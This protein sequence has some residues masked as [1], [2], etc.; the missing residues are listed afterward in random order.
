[1]ENEIYASVEDNTMDYMDLDLEYNSTCSEDEDEYN[2]F[3]YIEG[4]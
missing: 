2:L 3:I 4:V 1:M